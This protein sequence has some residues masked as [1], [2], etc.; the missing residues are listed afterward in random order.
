[1]MVLIKQVEDSIPLIQLIYWWH[2][3]FE[4]NFQGLEQLNEL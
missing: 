4:Q 2:A 1:M 3:L